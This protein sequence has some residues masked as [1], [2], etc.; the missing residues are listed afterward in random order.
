M[1]CSFRYCGISSPRSRRSLI[2]AWA[3]SRPTMMV[4][5][6]LRRVPMGYFV[7]ILQTSDIGWSRSIFT[8]LPSPALR[9]SSGIQRPGLSSSFSIQTPSALILHLILRSA[10]QLTPRPTGQLAPWR[11]RRMMRTSCAMYLPPNWAPRPILQ[12]S[13]HTFF[14]SSTSRKARPVSSPVVGRLS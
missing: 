14:S 10:E 4:P 8:A 12:A 11:G 9:S 5:F 1:G 13:S 6:R 7:R 2:F 3:M